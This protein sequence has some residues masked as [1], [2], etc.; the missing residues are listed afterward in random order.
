MTTN[1]EAPNRQ[2]D[3]FGARR[4]R[5]AMSGCRLVTGWNVT[6]KARLGGGDRSNV[7]RL[8]RA[9]EAAE[10]LD[11]KIELDES[12]RLDRPLHVLADAGGEVIGYA[13]VTADDDAEV[14]GM[15][16]PSWRRRGVGTAL[17]GG[18][19]GAARRLG[20]ESILVICE[21]AGQAGLAWM[22]GIGAILESTE[23]RMVL[24]LTS[25]PPTPL[26]AEARLEMRPASDPDRDAIVHVLGEDYSDRPEERRLVGV[27]GG[28]VVGTLRLTETTH[29][30]MIYGL[31]I[32]ERHRGRRLGTRLLAAVIEQ[33]RDEGIADVG[34]EVDPENTPAVRL[35][36]RFRFETVTTYRYM[37]LTLTPPERPG[38]DRAPERRGA[39]R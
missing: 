3:P 22:R 5:G 13:G 18:M 30:T 34:L 1:E 14:C 16:H 12:D 27:E 8:R 19:G 31:V 25:S 21:E 28:N 36:E 32:E 26:T 38:L 17:L 9:C 39:D 33:L 20:R 11:L 4:R 6:G 2:A 7:D 24:R 29:R 10:P 37:R 15:V 23:R 35:Y